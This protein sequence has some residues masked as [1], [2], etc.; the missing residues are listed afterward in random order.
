MLLNISTKLLFVFL[1]YPVNRKAC[2]TPQHTCDDF[3]TADP[4]VNVTSFSMDLIETVKV[5]VMVFKKLSI[6]CFRSIFFIVM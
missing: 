4:S 2:C 3:W 1:C 6:I 5:V